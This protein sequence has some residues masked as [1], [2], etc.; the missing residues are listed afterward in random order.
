MANGKKDDSTGKRAGMEVGE[1]DAEAHEATPQ[2]AQ[3]GAQPGKRKRQGKAA[4]GG[5]SAAA[6]KASRPLT[7]GFSE[8]RTN[9]ATRFKPGQVA[10]PHGRPKGSRHKLSEAFIS[11]LHA[12]FELHGIDVIKVVRAE[13][14]VD[15]LK[16][17]ASIV[18]KQFGI[19]ENSQDAFMRLW[20]AIS[21]GEINNM[22][23]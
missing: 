20:A 1:N 13:F 12:D 8:K 7:N 17:I 21:S 3:P 16:T 6:G 2:G 10:N 14:P 4:G 18:P 15:Y 23:A 9:E 5:A 11:A 19:E 22:I